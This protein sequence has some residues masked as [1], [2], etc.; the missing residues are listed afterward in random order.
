M[1]SRCK[2]I[3]K[4]SGTRCRNQ[5]APGADGFCRTH[6]KSQSAAKQTTTLDNI[7]NKA[8]VISAVAG[9]ATAV[10]KLIESVSAVLSAHAGV[11]FRTGTP[12]DFRPPSQRG[13]NEE[14]MELIRRSPHGL[15]RNP[16][17]LSYSERRSDEL[18]TRQRENDQLAIAAWKNDMSLLTSKAETLASVNPQAVPAKVLN[19]WHE[20]ENL[21]NK[22]ISFVP[23]WTLE[24][25]NVKPQHSTVKE[26][27]K[28]LDG[29]TNRCS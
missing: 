28:T 2:A 1:S 3:S 17:K 10:L 12:Y 6:Y 29:L 20:V 24:S 5:T 13:S 18:P 16:D 14:S 22:W 4:R 19:E 11:F 27:T 23:N 7:K 15:L 25:E 21:L 26:T 8:L 9:A